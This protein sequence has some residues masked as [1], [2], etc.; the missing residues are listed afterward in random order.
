ML[1]DKLQVMLE[2][3]SLKTSLLITCDSWS[4]IPKFGSLQLTQSFSTDHFQG[5]FVVEGS[6]H[7]HTLVLDTKECALPSYPRKTK[8]LYISCDPHH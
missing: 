7:T 3:Q 8:T 1:D 5:D 2:G 6:T 4:H